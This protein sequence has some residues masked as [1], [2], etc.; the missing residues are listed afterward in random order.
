MQ[1]SYHKEY[2][3]FLNRDMEYKIYGH[4][5]KPMLVFPTSCGRFYQYEDSGM[6]D[7]I[8]NFIDE[9]RLQVWTCDSIDEETF[10][11]E[12]WRIDEKVNKHEAYLNYIKEELIPSILYK[13]WETN[14]F[15]NQKILITGCSMG[16]YHSANF[17]FRYPEHI[18]SLIAL[19]GLYSTKYFFGAYSNTSVYFNSPLDYLRNLSDSYY[20][21]KYKESKIVVCCGQ[22]AYED[23]MK[24]ETLQLKEILK[25]KGITAWVDLWGTDVNHDWVWW[26]EQI[27]YYLNYFLY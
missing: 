23:E 7:A 16:A 14:N 25:N 4:K 8:H 3:R 22:G 11:S 24:E 15:T 13:S 18:D 19:S 21:D 5:G 26:K 9:G 10:F 1:I 2:S 17:F 12:D 27:K 20:L 6:I